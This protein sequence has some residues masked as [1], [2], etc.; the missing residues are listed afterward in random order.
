MSAAVGMAEAAPSH[1]AAL[2]GPAGQHHGLSALL[3]PHSGS[4]VVAAATAVATVPHSLGPGQ[5]IT[6]CLLLISTI[7]TIWGQVSTS[8]CFFP[9]D[10]YH[11]SKF[12][13][14]FMHSGAS[15]CLLGS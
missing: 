11:M 6:A 2:Q 13:K 4:G 9:Q 5:H 12:D 8:G 3:Q 10:C 7:I 15:A 1:A 14:E